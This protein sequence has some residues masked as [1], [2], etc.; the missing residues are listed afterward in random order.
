[1]SSLDIESVLEWMFVKEK[2]DESVLIAFKTLS[3][4]GSATRYIVDYFA[5]F[6]EKANPTH[7]D[8]NRLRQ[9]HN[10]MFLNYGMTLETNKRLDD[11][12]N[13]MNKR[14]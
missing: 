8:V 7:A 9:I 13:A 3:E 5:K 14:L 11:C 2:S 1:M 12:I 4:A 10:I 6:S